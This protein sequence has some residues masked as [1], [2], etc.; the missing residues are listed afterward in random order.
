[1]KPLLNYFF[2]DKPFT[3]FD[4]VLFMLATQWFFTTSPKPNE[5]FLLLLLLIIMGSV[6]SVV[7]TSLVKG[8]K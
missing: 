6:V 2:V 5:L 8:I 7:I 3:I 1:M 4:A